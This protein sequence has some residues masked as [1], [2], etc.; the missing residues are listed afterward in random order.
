MKRLTLGF[1]FFIVSVT[2]YSQK[3]Y[4]IYLQT[5]GDQPFFVKMNEKVYSSS[6]SGY[7]ILSKLK[8][9]TYNFSVGFPQNKWP[10]QNFSVAI[11]KKDH[12]YL[13]KN[14]AEKGWGLFDLQTLAVQMAIAGTS[15]MNDKPIQENKEVSPFTEILSKAANDPS[16]KEKTVQPKEEEKKSTIVN[17]DAEKKEEP[18]AGVIDSG[19]IK[20]EQPKETITETQQGIK[21]TQQAEVREQVVEKN[22]MIEEE[23]YQQSVVIKKS[24][25]ST[26]EGFG[27]VFI[28]NNGNG[29]NDTIRLLIPNPKPVI[30]VINEQAKEE[31]KFLDVTTD[32][33]SKTEVTLATKKQETKESVTG[34]SL[35]KNECSSQANENDFY[36][37][38]KNMAAAEGD[39]AMIDAAKKYFRVRCF[40]TEQIRNLSFLFLNDEGKYKFFDAAYNYVIDA[41]SFRSLQNDLKDEYYITRFKAMLRN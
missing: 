29:T 15:Q 13:V 11:N 12:G 18:K 2:V 22:K 39:D 37:L 19:E 40:T 35:V 17:A 41:S 8:D 33:V 6:A 4:F 31:K 1:L 10:E 26:T 27:L 23:A 38:R 20:K 3:V 9:T 7:L 24:E 30:N 21:E 14:F 32:T 28:D 34:K 36:Q 5:E 25:S 16:L